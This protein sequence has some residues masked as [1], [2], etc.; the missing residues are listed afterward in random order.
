MPAP[1]SLQDFLDQQRAEYLASLPGRLATLEDGWQ[2]AAGGDGAALV[3]LERCAHGL[4]GSAG[5]FGFAPIGDAARSLEESVESFTAA[6][7]AWDPAA[8]GRLAA[9]VQ[10]VAALLRGAIAAGADVPRS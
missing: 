9:Q 8:A 6:G 1:F 4:A 3:E 2:R 7:A 5:T 10:A